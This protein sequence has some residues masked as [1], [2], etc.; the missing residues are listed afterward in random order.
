L[1]TL[2]VTETG[3]L[4]EH[5][6]TIDI[7]SRLRMKEINLALDDFGIGYSSLTQLFRMPFNEMKIDKS[8]VLRTPESKEAQI[9]VDALVE[10]AQRGWRLKKL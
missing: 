1:L 5:A 7:L 4:E 9:M 6:D 2:E 10:L 3:M 8:L